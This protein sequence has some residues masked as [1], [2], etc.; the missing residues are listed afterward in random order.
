MHGVEQLAQLYFDCL[1]IDSKDRDMEKFKKL[2]SDSGVE[3]GP[4]WL[5]SPDAVKR[6][7]QRL[8]ELTRR[9]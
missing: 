4:H 5:T 8:K 6:V 1:G 7:N 3:L 2:V 9:I